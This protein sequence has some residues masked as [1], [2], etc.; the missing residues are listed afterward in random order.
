MEETKKI[1]EIIYFLSGPVIA[2]FAFMALHQ[3]KIAKQQL[4][5]DKNILRINSKRE[6]I[7]LATEQCDNYMK[8]IMPDIN[9][10]EE[11]LEKMKIDFLKKSKVTIEQDSISVEPYID[12]E[13]Y[14]KYIDM[15]CIRKRLKVE[16]ALETFSIY[17][18][19]GIADEKIAYL[20]LGRTYCYIVEKLLP[21][22]LY[23]SNDGEYFKNIIQLF[24]LWYFRIQQEKIQKEKSELEKKL[25]SIKTRG[26]NTIGVNI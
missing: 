25:G 24:N 18:T 2:V 1:L 14:K 15:N 22:I 17:F 6:S 19:S 16:N 23:K 5:N 13:D 8:N 3:I 26:I 20:T 4:E 9:E 12:D 10:L 7:K 21:D 11:Y